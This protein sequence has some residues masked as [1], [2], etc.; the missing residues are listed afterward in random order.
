MS[1]V[2]DF[3][4]WVDD[5]R[6]RYYGVDG[7]S[8]F[9]NAAQIMSTGKPTVIILAH[10]DIA[11]YMYLSAQPQQT[12]LAESDGGKLAK[13]VSG[14]HPGGT[15]GLGLHDSL[16]GIGSFWLLLLCNVLSSVW[17]DLLL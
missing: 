12:P 1:E 6:E 4:M 3:I 7:E 17:R 2:D 11:I 10:N 5:M 16:T 15:I 9:D 13:E 14:D 8:I